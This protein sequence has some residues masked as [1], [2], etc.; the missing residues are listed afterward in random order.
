MGFNNAEVKVCNLIT[1]SSRSE[2]TLQLTRYNTNKCATV[3]AAAGVT[4][5]TC[6]ETECLNYRMK[7]ADVMRSVLRILVTGFCNSEI[8]A[9]WDV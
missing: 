3:D 6:F 1:P 2:P 8:M 9:A 5:S 7:R 4:I